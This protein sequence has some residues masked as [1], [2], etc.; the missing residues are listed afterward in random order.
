MAGEMTV[1][2]NLTVADTIHVTTIQSATIDSLRAVIA[3]LQVQ[4]AVLQGQSNAISSKIVQIPVNINPNCQNSFNLNEFINEDQNWYRVT[5]INL[6]LDNFQG[7][8]TSQDLVEIGVGSW[9]GMNN[10]FAFPNQPLQ[11]EFNNSYEMFMPLE[12]S[13]DGDLVM[14]ILHDN[15]EIE[16]T[17][18]N[19][20]IYGGGT[21]NG[22]A[23]LTLLLESNF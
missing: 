4:L 10:G 19:W 15:P 9:T 11:L 18:S 8:D 21:Y 17:C 20:S 23:T 14:L 7:E 13:Y 1:D 22:T 3:D 2:G 6:Q 5:Y 16:L 12:S